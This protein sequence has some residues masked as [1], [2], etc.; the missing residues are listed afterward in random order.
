M[1]IVGIDIGGTNIRI[2]IINEEM[3]LTAF[4]KVPQESVLQNDSLE[5]FINFIK[6][7]ISKNA[8]SMEISAMAIGVPATLDRERTTV[9]NAPNV[10]GFNGKNIKA[11]LQVHFD[12]PIYIEKDVSMLFYYDIHR[13]CIDK[14]GVV[15]A[16]YIGTGIGNV[17]SIDGKL[18]TGNNGAAG[19]LGH[20]PVWDSNEVCTCGNSGCI[21]TLVGGKYLDKLRLDLFPCTDI[22]DFFV[23]Q[24]GHPAME[25][26]IRHLALPIATEINILDPVTVILGGGVLSMAGFPKENL[27]RQIHAYA[28][29]PLPE[30]NLKFIYSDNSG[31]NGVI[32]AGLFA[33]EMLRKG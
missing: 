26:Y 11:L 19:E 16:C 4:H 20:I 7:Y 8:S 30:Q 10:H 33:L 28:R 18:L 2:G 32:G 25:T 15:I 9:L 3:Q 23:E 1:N 12:Y 17:I 5:G 22:S 24:A 14:A 13:F 27:E 21:E 29:K 6:S 31:G